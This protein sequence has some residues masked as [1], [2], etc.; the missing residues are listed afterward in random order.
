MGLGTKAKTKTKTKTQDSFYFIFCSVKVYASLGLGRL[1]A[2]TIELKGSG[3][4]FIFYSF[5]LC[6]Y[7]VLCVFFL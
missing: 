3:V 7:T 4:Y 5:P 2:L 6:G 1:K